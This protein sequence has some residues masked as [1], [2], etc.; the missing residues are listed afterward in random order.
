[1]R[2]TKLSQ[3]ARRNEP[4]LRPFPRIISADALR[5]VDN[6]G[7]EERLAETLAR[8]HRAQEGGGAEG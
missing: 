5:P 1:M 6:E 7:G 2:H 4:R 8:I 3:A